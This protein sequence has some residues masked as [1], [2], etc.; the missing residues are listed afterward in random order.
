MLQSC[1]VFDRIE[2]R[3]ALALYEGCLLMHVGF[4][5]VA[6]E[7]WRRIWMNAKE[8][9]YVENIWINAKKSNVGWTRE[10]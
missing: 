2:W 1:L 6:F 5:V 10:S 9:L 3:E 4:F 8:N 7:Y